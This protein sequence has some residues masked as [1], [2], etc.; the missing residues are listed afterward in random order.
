MVTL[1]LKG[2]GLNLTVECSEGS[3]CQEAI[4]VFERAS[5]KILKGM[6]LYAN[7]RKIQ[8]LSEELPEGVEEFVAVQSKHASA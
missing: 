5:G 1:R 3:T 7:G 8:D 2:A 4:D 6:D